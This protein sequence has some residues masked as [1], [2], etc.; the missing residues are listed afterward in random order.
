[1]VLSELLFFSPCFQHAGIIFGATITGF[2]DSG[3]CGMTRRYTDTNKKAVS[4]SAIRACFQI[5]A[6]RLFNKKRIIIKLEI[7]KKMYVKPLVEVVEVNVE[8]QILAGSPP[9]EFEITVEPLTPDDDEELFGAKDFNR[10]DD[11]K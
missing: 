2:D 6:R 10:W 9:V 4:A 5:A 8:D 3:S 11:W 7:M 1:M